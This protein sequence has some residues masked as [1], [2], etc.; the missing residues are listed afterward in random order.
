MKKIVYSVIALFIVAIIVVWG[1]GLYPV[2]KVSSGYIF[3]R[4][5]DGRLVVSEHL[6][7]LVGKG[8]QATYGRKEALNEIIVERVVQDAV[9]EYKLSDQATAD[10]KTVTDAADKDKIEQATEK[11]YGMS[12]KDFTD[13]VLRPAAGKIT[14]GKYI[15]SRGEQYPTWIENRL[16]A[17][18]VH[19]YFLPY[20]WSDGKLENT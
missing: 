7:D 1:F 17:T 19:V 16:K 10:L 13:A 9:V 5:V 20:R 4:E 6:K 18:Q 2:A 3:M 11:L 15:E 8:V 12:F 14:L